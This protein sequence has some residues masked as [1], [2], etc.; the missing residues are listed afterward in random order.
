MKSFNRIATSIALATLCTVSMAAAP[1]ALMAEELQPAQTPSAAT[2]R[3]F[4]PMPAFLQPP[5]S[6]RKLARELAVPDAVKQG[7]AFKDSLTS[8]QQE[9]VKAVLGRFVPQ[10]KELG[11]QSKALSQEGARQPLTAEAKQEIQDLSRQLSTIQEQI[12]SELSTVVS[13]EQAE[14]FKASLKPVGDINQVQQTDSN[15]STDYNSTYSTNSIFYLFYAYT[16]AYYSYLNEGHHSEAYSAYSYAYTA[17]WSAVDANNDPGYYANFYNAYDYADKAYN[18]AQTN[19]SYA[20]DFGDFA[21]T[22]A[23]YGLFYSYLAWDA[24]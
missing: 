17:Y 3:Q 2:Q 6:S 5:T 7:K 11:K 12:A 21:L 22:Y 14:L 4:R 18:A 13:P 1:M 10:F 16:M 24:F 8:V 9:Q 19:S 20:G 23:V 15:V